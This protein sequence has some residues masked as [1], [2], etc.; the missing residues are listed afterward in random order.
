MPPFLKLPDFSS[1]RKGTPSSGLGGGGQP[2]TKVYSCLFTRDCSPLGWDIVVL[3]LQCSPFNHHLLFAVCNASR[4]KS[5][6]IKSGVQ[7]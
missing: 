7:G 1:E 2:F 3:C 6:L 5:R 4:V